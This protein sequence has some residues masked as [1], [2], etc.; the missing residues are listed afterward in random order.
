[1]RFYITQLKI[2][3]IKNIEKEI[4]LDFYKKTINKTFDLNNSN[5]KS[6]Y[7]ENGSGKSG[8]IHAMDIYKNLV[9]D[10]KYLGDKSN[11]QYLNEL[12][13]KKLNEFSISVSFLVY[14]EKKSNEIF[15]YFTH[16]ISI[17]KDNDSNYFYIKLDRLIEHKNRKLSNVSEIYNIENGKIKY[18]DEKVFKEVNEVTK[19]LLKDKSIGSIILE[20]DFLDNKSLKSSDFFYGITFL[21]LLSSNIYVSLENSD[22]HAMFI[23]SKAIQLEVKEFISR[24]NFEQLERHISYFPVTEYS[25][26]IEKESSKQYESRIK[27]LEKFIK[28]FKSQ[29]LRIELDR[30]KYDKNFYVYDKIFVY[31]DYAINT[32]FESTGI[33]KLITLFSF[34]E[35]LE[36]GKVVF[37]DELDAN[38]HDVYLCKMLEYFKEYGKGQLCFTTHNMGPMQVLKS[39]NYS[40]DFLSNNSELTSWKKTGNYSVQNLYR[41]GM[42]KNSPFNIDAID[43]IDVFNSRK[44]DD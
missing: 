18:I 35:E 38:L 30:K 22:K 1:M 3:G 29:L 11:S 8:I 6:I 43:F 15:E 39:S 10:S 13:N 32:E 23:R 2:K 37:I 4:T 9:I 34:L 33:K 14:D 19:N 40:I 17:E 5:I 41:E 26:I 27:R 44:V 24:I 36:K 16:M 7:G 31:E 28:I 25:Q 20:N 12:V 21:V 42:I